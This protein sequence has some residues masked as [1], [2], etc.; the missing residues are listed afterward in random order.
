MKVWKQKEKYRLDNSGIIHLAALKRGHS[1]SFRLSVTLREKINPLLLQQAFDTVAFRFPTIVAGI[2][3][4]PFRHFVVPADTVPNIRFD[5]QPLIY[6]TLKQI[7][8][9]AICVLYRDTRIAVEFFHS[10]TDGYGG[11]QFLK[12]LLAEY[13]HLAYKMDCSAFPDIL[14]WDAPME[15]EETEDSYAVYA[16]ERKAKLNHVPS[17][18]ISG[19]SISIAGVHTTTA[20]FCLEKLLE[21]AHYYHVTL[22]TL[23]TA[24][25]AA[26]VMELQ[27]CKSSGKA[28]KAVQI[29]VPVNLRKLFPSKSLR[30][31]SLYALPQI[32]PEDVNLPFEALLK[33]INGQLKEQFS[34]KSF[35]SMITTNVG[36]ERNPLCCRLP[37]KMK[38]VGLH[39]A[40][41]FFGSRNSSISLSNL[42]ELRF[43][44]SMRPYI[45]RT[46]FLLTPRSGGSYNCG[47]ASYNGKLYVN[48]TRNCVEPVL[49]RI[50]LRRFSEL[51]HI[52]R[53]EVD[54][55]VRSSLYSET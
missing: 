23:L 7:R 55:V 15:I 25:M 14:S 18:Q 5:G 2:Q 50:F 20:V 35:Q 36:L 54:G 1:N 29:M 34:T 16:G 10:L 48:F 12:A 37:L 32:A 9:C 44:E 27:I 6:M 21:T 38:C 46:E 4:G 41:R 47:V 30:N 51:G 45:Q 3:S 22:T 33:K 13:L 28:M 40:F 42:G 43:P 19:D 8:S 11:F 52:P 17:Y 26:S 31:F 53:V 39:A 24:V 49:E